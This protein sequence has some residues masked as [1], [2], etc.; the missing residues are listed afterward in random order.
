MTLYELFPAGLLRQAIADGYVREQNHPQLPLAILNYSEKAAY[1]RAWNLCARQCRGLIYRTDTLEVV[2]R[3]FPKFFNYGEPDA[4]H[5]DLE[6]PAV[7]TDKMDGSLGILYPHLPGFSI[8]TRGSF[9]SEQALHATKVWRERYDG[10]SPHPELTYLFE[11]VYAANRVVLDYGDTDDLFL[12]AILDTATHEPISLDASFYPGPR[13]QTHDYRTLAE[14]LAAEPRENAEGYVVYFPDT[15]DRVKLKQPD[16]VALHRILTGTNARHVYEF[17][18]VRAC[19]EAIGRIADGRDHG[20]LWASFVGLDPA[21]VEQLL[22]AG[23]D[24]L[25]ETGVPDEFYDWVRG[26]IDACEERAGQ[27]VLAAIQV[28]RHA[29]DESWSRQ[30]QYR[31]VEKFAPPGLVSETMR[32]AAGGGRLELD[33]VILR[34]WREAAPAPSAPFQRSEAVA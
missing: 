14:A 3:P 24:W 27:S 31:Y 5:I 33:R 10:W 32:L 6:A 25:T 13:V 7:V 4:P 21:R 20:K 9:A 17:A 28:A 8:A 12:L 29:A 19:A 15:G 30:E 22:A 1:E 23:D 16:Y 2:A 34:A 11:I 26:V 18:A